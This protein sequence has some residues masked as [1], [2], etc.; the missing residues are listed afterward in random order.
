MLIFKG[1]NVF[2]LGGLGTRLGVES[3]ELNSEV[4]LI[5]T[6]VEGN[7]ST[8][9]QAKIHK[10]YTCVFKL[11]ILKRESKKSLTYDGES[12]NG[13]APRLVKTPSTKMPFFPLQDK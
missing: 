8:H 13:G 7:L 4:N 9:L 3:F 5:L 1:A 6:L 2:V 12:F 11:A 10:V